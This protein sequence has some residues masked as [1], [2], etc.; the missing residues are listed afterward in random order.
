MY[1]T[2]INVRNFLLVKKNIF[3]RNRLLQVVNTPNKIKMT[4]SKYKLK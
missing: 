1:L 4:L 2:K 3:H